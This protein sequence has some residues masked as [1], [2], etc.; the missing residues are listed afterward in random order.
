MIRTIIKI[1]HKKVKRIDWKNVNKSNTKKYK[2][3]VNSRLINT[4]KDKILCCQDLLC[5]ENDHKDEIDA[6]YETIIKA[7]E[8]SA[9]SSFGSVSSNNDTNAKNAKRKQNKIPGW[10]DYVKPYKESADT[11]RNIWESNGRVRDNIIFPIYKKARNTFHLKVK[12]LRKLN[13]VLKDLN[14]FSE[15]KRNISM[16]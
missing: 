3:M 4:E 7:M 16:K 13:N 10:S 8:D 5:Q 15:D 1:K 6:L 12:K 9:V 2:E 11:W 14:I